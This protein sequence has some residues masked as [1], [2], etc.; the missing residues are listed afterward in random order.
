MNTPK[1]GR[2]RA[3]R[4]CYRKM[5]Q[6]IWK[7]RG[8]WTPVYAI[9]QQKQAGAEYQHYMYAAD[10]TPVCAGVTRHDHMNSAIAAQIFRVWLRWRAEY[11][12]HNPGNYPLA[13]CPMPASLVAFPV[14]DP[15]KKQVFTFSQTA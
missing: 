10:G 1:V 5:G 7:A 13:V 12:S 11:I 6:G 2:T 8:E 14:N 9:E 4:G 15:S 3:A